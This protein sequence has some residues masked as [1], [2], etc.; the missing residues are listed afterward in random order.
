MNL[1]K[2]T[3]FFLFIFIFLNTNAYSFKRKAVVNINKIIENDTLLSE[4][5]QLI[6]N[7]KKKYAPDTRLTVF[8]VNITKD[9]V[10]KT[11]TISGE[12]NIKASSDDLMQQL[13]SRN[14]I[15]KNRIT[16]LPETKLGDSTYALI[17]VSVANIRSGSDYSEEMVTQALMGTPVRVYK[18]DGFW[19][20]IQTPDN[21]LG[22]VSVPSIKRFTKAQIKSWIDSPRLMYIKNA[23]VVYEDASDKSAVVS[24]IVSGCILKIIGE[25]KKF[26]KVE[27][28]DKKRVG[29][30]LKTEGMIYEKWLSSRN[31]APENIVA[32]AKTFMGHP[33]LWG[34]T[35]AK[36]MDCSGFTRLVYFLNG[37]ILQ[38]DASQQALYG[39]P[40]DTVNSFAELQ[41]GDL[42]FFGSNGYVGHVAIS[43]GGN[44]YIHSGGI[45]QINSFDPS[46]PNFSPY[47]L[48][49]LLKVKRLLTQIGKDGIQN[50]KDNSFYKG[51]F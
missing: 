21:Y 37:V 35:S 39:E 7:V 32:T 38:R 43:L 2:S 51:E 10:D 47:D 50:I 28:A 30:I 5:Q 26:Y 27:F 17:N 19:Y 16:I 4:I 36:G 24:D 44:D 8:T 14:I 22:W 42:L 6:T 49:I 34:G 12:T 11:F 13:K 41:P 23:G 46:K 1:L 31:S 20:Y 33:Y 40:V 3:L 25:K 9:S 18:R 48:K 15:F 29:Y 45:L